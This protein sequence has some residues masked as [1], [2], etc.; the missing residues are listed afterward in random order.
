MFNIETELLTIF[1]TGNQVD[2]QA[3][4]EYKKELKNLKHDG[5]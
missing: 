3:N 4:T 1:F 5:A 2:V